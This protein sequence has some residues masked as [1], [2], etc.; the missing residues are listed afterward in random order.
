M[1]STRWGGEDAVD[2]AGHVALQAAHDLAFGQPL[3]GPASL[4]ESLDEHGRGV[5]ALGPVVGQAPADDGEDVRAEIGYLDP[6]QDE[7][8]RIVDHQREV[9]LAQLRRPS[10]EPVARGRSYAEINAWLMDRC[11]EDAKKRRHPTI[12]GK[13]VWQVFEGP[14]GWRKDIR[15]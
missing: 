12:E 3:Q 5:V 6:G 11:I 4:Y 8:P 14:I 9:L 10:D 13:T 1:S 2:L 7:E 15:S